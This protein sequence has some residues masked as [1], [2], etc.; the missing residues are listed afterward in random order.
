MLLLVGGYLFN[1]VG[2]FALCILITGIGLAVLLVFGCC[3][4]TGGLGD[5]AWLL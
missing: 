3:L 2:V 1:S 5:S 4:A